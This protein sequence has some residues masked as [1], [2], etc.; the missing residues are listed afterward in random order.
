M[1]FKK[2]TKGLAYG[3]GL[4]LVTGQAVAHGLDEV[5]Q[6]VCLEANFMM[7]NAMNAP[8]AAA[9]GPGNV[10]EV[11]IVTGARGIT[12]NNPFGAAADPAGPVCENG[13]GNLECPGPFKPTGVLSGGLNGHAFITSAGQQALTQFHRDGTPI[14][15]VS[16]RPLIGNPT[17]PAGRGTI[18]RPLGNQIMPNGNIVQAICDANFFNAQNSDVL[19]PGG[20]TS[21]TGNS[22]DLFFPPVYETAARAANSR[23]LV[24]D[25]ETM[26]V[27]DEYNQPA[28]QDARW[29]C[30]AGLAFTEE[31]MGVSMFHGA[32]IAMVDWKAGVEKESCGV[33]CNKA[34]T[35]NE[36]S[37]GHHREHMNDEADDNDSVFQLNKKKNQAQVTR[38]IDLRPGKP[39]DDPSRRDS[40][41]A[42]GLD[43][44]G[45]IYV[46]D[47]A[48]SR[49][50]V[51]GEI[52]GTPG[53]CNPSVFRQRIDVVDYGQDAPSRTIG[54][55]PGVNV[56]AGLRPNR[57]SA[58][59][60]ANIGG[61]T[62]NGTNPAGTSCDVETLLI[63]ASAFNPGCTV[64]GTVPPAECFVQGGG[65]GEYSIL[66]EDADA[67]DGTCTGEQA[68]GQSTYAAGGVNS[69][70]AQP[71][72][73]FLGRANGNNVLVDDFVDPRMLMVIHEAFVQ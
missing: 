51:E 3:I 13:S 68:G 25:Q 70:C 53:G 4:A 67:T 43:E 72:A 57:M 42:W 41:R 60:C 35:D 15:T 26:Q 47:R 62:A 48:R 55:D 29:T 66:P 45:T 63:A 61:P 64:T 73:T 54:L 40:L 1:K 37:N 18:P 69:G 50:C 20:N 38:W 11:N 8:F 49:D 31:G 17:G 22:S 24:I 21:P 56:I 28:D 19:S 46:T 36:E 32:A 9:D 59:A 5:G 2:V 39:A 33:G 12:V 27:I 30:M 23:I 14:K 6:P 71:L 34:R 52:P 16:F 44:D 10:L 7:A 65:V 58:V